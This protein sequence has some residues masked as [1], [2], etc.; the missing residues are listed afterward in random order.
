MGISVSSQGTHSR[1]CLQAAQAAPH[2]PSHPRAQPGARC[3]DAGEMLTE[4]GRDR[5]APY[6][7]GK[8][9]NPEMPCPGANFTSKSALSLSPGGS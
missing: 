4:P 1:G 6:T 9:R 7:A 8:S 3:M 5:K 2:P